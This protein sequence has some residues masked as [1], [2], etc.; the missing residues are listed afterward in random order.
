MNKAHLKIV[1][2]YL[3][4]MS[5]KIIKISN[6]HSPEKGDKMA[7]KSKVCLFTIILIS[8]VGMTLTG[9]QTKNLTD[10]TK[11]V[12][13]IAAFGTSV[14]EAQKNL[15]DFDTLACERF[16][17]HDI[18]WAFTSQTIVDKLRNSGQDTLYDRKVPLKTLEELYND[19]QKEGKTKIAVQPI[20]ISPGQEYYEVVTTPSQGLNT[21][22]GL[23]LLVYDEEIE[24][25]AKIISPQFQTTDSV[26]ILCGHGNDHQPQFNASLMTLDDVVRD[27]YTN[28]FVATVEGKPGFEQAMQDTKQTG[29]NKVH[30]IPVMLVAG[31]HIMN[32]VMGEDDP[33]SWKSQLGLEATADSGLGSNP[34]VMELFLNRIERLLN[35]F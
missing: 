26:T 8:I 34:Q 29:F 30:F 22:V 2:Q 24:E 35:M 17:D 7:M 28:V 13:A 1:N 23:P 11:P 31:D 3:Y 12:I 9:C 18:R 21:K 10:N 15:E 6:W 16:P 33:E 27:N 19:L 14:P 5:A 25:F 4:N 20:H 32:D